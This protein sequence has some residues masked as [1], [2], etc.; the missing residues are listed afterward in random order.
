M[1]AQH[2]P[3]CGHKSLAA[4]AAAGEWT[5]RDN[6]RRVKETIKLGIG[7]RLIRRDRD[8][9]RI[10]SV[11]DWVGDRLVIRG[12]DGRR[13]YVVEKGI[14]DQL[15]VRDFVTNAR[16]LYIVP[17]I[18]GRLEIQDRDGRRVGEIEPD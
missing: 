4:P 12:R 14:G 5:I 16:K 17:G 10:G 9:R 18:G 13:R 8:G 15:V 3:P 2:D 1:R 11:K 7:D 6:D